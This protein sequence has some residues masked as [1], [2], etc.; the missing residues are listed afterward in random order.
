MKRNKSKS[1]SSYKSSS[2][3]GASCQNNSSTRP[4]SGLNS[5][6]SRKISE[7][8]SFEASN[9]M[10]RPKLCAQMEKMNTISGPIKVNSVK[11]MKEHKYGIKSKV[12]WATDSIC[13]AN[14]PDHR[15]MIVKILQ[16]RQC[17]VRYKL[18]M[19]RYS[20]KIMRFIGQ[21]PLFHTF[22]IIYEIF[23]V[24]NQTYY[25]YMSASGERS[26]YKLITDK[27][28]TIDSEKVRTWL[29]QLTESVNVIQK[30]GIAHR[31]L[32][33]RHLL[34]DDDDKNIK[35]VGWSKSVLFWDPKKKKVLYQNKER[36]SRKNNF[37]PPEAFHRLYDPSKA[38]VWAL[39]I[40]LV[41]LS[42]RRYPFHVRAKNKFSTQW[43]AF[44]RKH[45]MNP[46]VRS[47][48]NRIFVIDTKKR[49]HAREMLLHD[50]FKVMNKQLL[51]SSVRGKPLKK[52]NKS[53][54][55][56]KSKKDKDNKKTKPK[57]ISKFHKAHHSTKE[58][59][60]V[61]SIGASKAGKS[62][63][64]SIGSKL[65]SK[66]TSK[67]K[68]DMSRSII[69]GSKTSNTRWTT[70][71][72]VGGSSGSLKSRKSSTSKSLSVTSYRTSSQN[73]KQHESKST[74]SKSMIGGSNSSSSSASSSHGSKN[75]SNEVA[76]PPG[77]QTVGE[78]G[79]VPVDNE[80]EGVA[81]E[82][83]M[84]APE[85]SELMATPAEKDAD[86]GQMDDVDANSTNDIAKSII[87]I[88][89][90]T[91]KTKLKK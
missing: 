14:G 77:E 71:S 87:G 89:T 82:Q 7:T 62:S 4:S 55:K 78:D 21:K 44:V 67:S 84:A 47:L 10:G 50:Y 41:A 38:D 34:L 86:E 70:Q 20:L 23:L 65:K 80:D 2:R 36:K 66:S 25:I 16:L 18:T 73:S 54:M 28:S 59:L 91:S 49:I 40:V 9:V 15:P 37:L 6:N 45:P 64:L 30:Y 3:I 39:G 61:S 88:E 35:I 8:K 72:T 76:D 90:K 52:Q 24:S 68:R 51:S 57:S 60:S 5:F 22:P 56:K 33:L 42:T 48:C 32:K 63:S 13:M 69:G 79:E 31:F 19:E 81:D 27:H 43:R 53:K 12:K 1:K 29:H 58:P 26:L 74:A 85:E 46:I 11:E 17:T 83:E 75:K